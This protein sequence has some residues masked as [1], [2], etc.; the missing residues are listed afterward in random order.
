MDRLRK[1]IG[2][3]LLA[4]ATSLLPSPDFHLWGAVARLVRDVDREAQKSGGC[5]GTVR[6]K[7][8]GNKVTIELT[9]EAANGDQ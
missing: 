4:V 5:S 7:R 8:V 2:L 1:H 9:K 6:Y 3:W